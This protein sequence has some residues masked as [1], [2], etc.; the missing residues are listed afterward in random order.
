MLLPPVHDE[1]MGVPSAAP[2]PPSS[3]SQPLGPFFSSSEDLLAAA[4]PIRRGRT[5]TPR[6][7]PMP[8]SALPSSSSSTLPVS[9][10]VDLTIRYGKLESELHMASQE[11]I[12][13]QEGQEH[14]RRLGSAQYASA[15]QAMYQVAEVYL[16]EGRHQPL[17]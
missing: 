9:D 8:F 2:P 11:A 10:L 1:A 16:E 3:A 12:A 14:F 15:K 4:G 6:P 7:S 17:R 5:P 13:A